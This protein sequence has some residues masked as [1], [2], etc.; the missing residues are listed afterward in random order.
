LLSSVP[1]FEGLP[2]AEGTLGG[3][4][5]LATVLFFAAAFM[6]YSGLVLSSWNSIALSEKVEL[7]LLPSYEGG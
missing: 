3:G 2:F 1:G 7:M 5:L 6:V 4:V